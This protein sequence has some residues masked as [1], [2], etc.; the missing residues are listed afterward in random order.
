[1]HASPA[2]LAPLCDRLATGLD[3]GIDIRRLLRS[4]ADRATGRRRDV[5]ERLAK[6]VAAGEPLEEAVAAEGAYF[7]RMLVELVRVGERTGRQPAVLKRLAR[8]YEHQLSA[9][10]TF[11]GKI[12][13]PL[14]QLVAAIGVCA[15]L[16]AIGGMIS[17]PR[18]GRGIDLLGLGLSGTSGVFIFL[19]AIAVLTTMAGLGWR[20]LRS[21]PGSIEALLAR[22]SRLPVVGEALQKLALERIAWSLA[23]LLD[24]DLD[25]RHVA[26]LSLAAAGNQRYGRH[27]EPVANDLGRGMPL[28]TALAHTGEFPGDFLDTLVV[29]EEGGRLV[30]SL[31]KLT[32]R[33]QE[34]AERAISTLS[35][36]LAGL[37]W[38]AIVAIIVALIFRVF[39][40]YTGVLEDALQ[41]I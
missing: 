19:G 17:D 21:Q 20:W 3:A 28:S 16:I 23:M 25:M 18:T 29:A 31:G 26:R 7:P 27:I 13:W 1:M 9:A 34:E 14:L 4:E 12:A 6:A 15:L 37:V 40:F 33:Y 35:M 41:G 32:A 8:H 2:E 36:A 38:L 39:G 30:E 10:R 11:R 22:A 5:C 24:T